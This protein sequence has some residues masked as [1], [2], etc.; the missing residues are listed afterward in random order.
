MILLFYERIIS[1]NLLFYEG[2]IKLQSESDKIYAV[3]F[4]VA[5]L[6]KKGIN[7]I[8]IILRDVILQN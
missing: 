6:K 8:F 1:I 5:L 7:D 4:T 3:N 2:I